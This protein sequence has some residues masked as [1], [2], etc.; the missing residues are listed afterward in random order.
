MSDYSDRLTIKQAQ[1]AA[2]FL[3]FGFACRAARLGVR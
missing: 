2:G 3:D 1:L